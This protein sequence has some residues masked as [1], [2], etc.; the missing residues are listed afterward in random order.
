V[1]TTQLR[2][3]LNGI[4]EGTGNNTERIGNKVKLRNLYAKLFVSGNVV[5]T[6]NVQYVRVVI[7]WQANV[8]GLAPSA[9]E[10][11]ETSQLAIGS[12]RNIDHTGNYHVFYDKMFALDPTSGRNTYYEDINIPLGMRTSQYDGVTSLVDSIANGA[13]WFFAVSN[14]PTGQGLTPSITFESRLRY[15]DA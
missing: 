15:T 14:R 10:V 11:W 3:L 13:L 4:T 6:A 5:D 12:Q 7:L 1:S 2:T 9:N 8:R